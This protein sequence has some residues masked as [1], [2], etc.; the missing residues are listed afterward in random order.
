MATKKYLK[1]LRVGD[2]VRFGKMYREPLAWI[3]AEK[4]HN[5]YPSNSVTLTT[6]K[7][8][9]TL[10]FDGAEPYAENNDMKWYGRGRYKVSNISQWLQS[11]AS[12]TN[13]YSAQHVV[14]H[15]PSRGYV[16][17]DHYEDF[18]GFLNE[19][20][21]QEV[22][23]LIETTRSVPTCPYFGV[24]SKESVTAKMFLLTD[25]ELGWATLTKD[26]VQWYRTASN[27]VC[28]LSADAVAHAQSLGGR[29]LSED[30]AYPMLTA[31]SYPSDRD[32]VYHLNTSG[33]LVQKYAYCSAGIRPACNLS[34]D[35]LITSEP[36]EDGY[37]TVVVNYAPTEPAPIRVEYEDEALGSNTVRSG[38]PI[39]VSW[40]RSTDSD[41]NF[42]HYELERRYGDGEWTTV[43]SGTGRT[44]T[45]TAQYGEESVQFR[46][47][48]VDYY[49]LTSEYVAATALTIW[50]NEPP[51]ITVD[52]ETLG[53]FQMTGPTVG[54][55]FR[56]PD[57]TA[58][59]IRI[60][61]DGV[62]YRNFTRTAATTDTS[63]NFTFTAE[64]WL[65]IQNGEHTIRFVVTDDHGETSTA[66]ATFTKAVTQ[67]QFCRMSP[68]Q[69]TEQPTEIIV[70]V[71]G[72]IP[73]G[74]V[75]TV[76]VCNN[77]FDSSPTWEDMTEEVEDED[78]YTFTNSTKTAE[79]WG[80][81]Y[82]ITVARGTATEDIYI[83]SV[84][85]NFLAGESSTSRRTALGVQVATE[86]NDAGG[87][88]LIVG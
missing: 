56:D 7:Y 77:A 51:S 26:I 88:T 60:T 50:S 59:A 23:M 22:D 31:S 41:N 18:A 54:F 40:A 38:K 53:T 43:Y 35:T 6:E 27:R 80:V 44:Y 47:R 52:N 4:E 19:F 14:D 61:V 17:Y 10:A 67:I 30:E 28:R 81:D 82:R 46:V 13:W 20:D 58:I 39:T 62:Q 42:D 32:S 66:T 70:R 64:E 85:S 74:A 83:E 78:I 37:Y 57:A 65:K 63:E 9:A 75:L 55:K 34:G 21:P 71:N 45:E 69:A 72:E 16:D 86:E 79:L 12:A 11:T 3:I 25:E 48:A 5:G 73:E 2:K 87:E 15:S 68:V 49:D 33:K 1:S 29:N 24:G 36:D 76:E 8:V 84:T